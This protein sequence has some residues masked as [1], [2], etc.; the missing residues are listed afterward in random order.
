MLRQISYDCA[1]LKFS[2]HR[3]VYATFQCTVSVVNEVVRDK[4]SREI[5]LKRKSEVGKSGGYSEHA[6][7]DEEDL[8]DFEPL[9]PGCKASKLLMLWL[10][11]FL[12]L[13]YV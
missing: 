2:D 10:A 11:G 3:P 1:P 4:M 13:I 5:Y 8:L 12:I 7:E 6:T 9:E